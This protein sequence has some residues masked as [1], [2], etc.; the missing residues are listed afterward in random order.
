MDGR[1]APQGLDAEDRIAL[2]LTA[3]HLFYLVA[4][5]ATGW[6]L[7]SS[8]LPAAVRVP[9]G[10]GLMAA[11]AALAWVRIAGRPLDRWIFLYAQYRLRPRRSPLPAA[12]MTSNVIPLTAVVT[13]AQTTT[14]GALGP[15]PE[16]PLRTASSEGAA[17]VLPLRAPAGRR[18]RRVAFFSLRGGTG[19]STLATEVA[20]GLAAGKWGDPAP[21]VAVFDLDSRAST[22]CIRLGLDTAGAPRLDPDHD[23]DDAVLEAAL[24]R[25]DSGARVLPAPP[26]GLRATPA[27]VARLLNHVD[28]NG[29]DLVLVDLATG[30]DDLNSYLLEAVDEIFYVFEPSAAGIFDLYRGVRTLRALG[31]RGK[32]HGVPNRGDADADLAEVVGDLRIPIQPGIQAG[33]ELARAEDAH[34]P[35]VLES[36]D[37]CLALRSL[38]VAVHPD[39]ELAVAPGLPWAQA[40]RR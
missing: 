2:G 30:V 11:G 28:R 33:H 14:V 39:S 26:G 4:F 17:V 38:A 7:L 21:R 10:V 22:S 1:R 16:L 12:H 20:I 24:L 36:D 29:F 8:H 35:A 40:M 37:V 34:R 25:H 31:H 3:S 6:G 13:R 32:V 23:I 19:K 5:S 9:P 18:A 27:V 15:P